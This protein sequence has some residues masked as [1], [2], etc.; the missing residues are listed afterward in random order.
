MEVAL[1][2]EQ[3]RA[4]K[5]VGARNT[6]LVRGAFP[7]FL[8]VGPQRTGTTWLASIL[9]KHPAVRIASPKELYYFSHLQSPCHAFDVVYDRSW[10][11]LRTRPN[12]WLL[13]VAR[14]YYAKHLGRH[15]HSFRDL[16]WY[17][18]HFEESVASRVAAAIDGGDL[19]RKVRPVGRIGEATASYAV[20]DGEIISD[21]CAI[22]PEIRVIVM[23]RDPVARAW[24]HAR[25][26]LVTLPEREFADVC[27]RD[28][29]DFYAREYQ[30]ASGTYSSIV[31]AWR[32][33]L[34]KGHLLVGNYAAIGANPRKLYS[35]ICDFL[36]IGPEEGPAD[37]V[38]LRVV[39]PAR[40]K[41][42]PRSHEAFLAKLFREERI[43]VDEFLNGRSSVVV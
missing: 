40:E 12:R 26:D 34:R 15:G 24:S 27:E 21:I 5:V 37:D 11:Q 1:T 19:R 18:T 38:L 29:L 36:D 10:K 28:F 35:D 2:R 31:P 17:L 22:N 4:L 30:I 16:E 14:W 25:K 3:L 42:L 23:M 8:I 13:N 41:E 33:W 43:Y 20:L 9:R 39:N 32:A 6:Q 7:D